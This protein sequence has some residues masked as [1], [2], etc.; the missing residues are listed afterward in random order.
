[1]DEELYERGR[2]SIA[3]EHGLSAESARRLRGKTASE[4]HTDARAMA[5]ELG[6]V[7]PTE[8]PRDG[9]G[10]FASGTDMNRI[11]RE[12]SGRR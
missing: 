8:R 1:V 5:A 4:L 7:D 2:A 9:A 11:I 3:A 6:V 12:A 10:R